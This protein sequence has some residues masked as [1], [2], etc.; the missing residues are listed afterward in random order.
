MKR[1]PSIF[2]ESG[3]PSRSVPGGGPVLL[4]FCSGLLSCLIM[5]DP[6][7]SFELG[8]VVKLNVLNSFLS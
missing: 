1:F 7:L 4:W 6:L 8:G 5:S 2:L 3:H